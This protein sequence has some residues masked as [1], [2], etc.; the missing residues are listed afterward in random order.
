VKCEYITYSL[1]Y[2]SA[3]VYPRILVILLPNVK[4]MDGV[5]QHLTDFRAVL[6]FGLKSLQFTIHTLELAV[7][8]VDGHLAS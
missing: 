7:V 2:V 5:A 1:V 6:L 8:S 4:C 3:V